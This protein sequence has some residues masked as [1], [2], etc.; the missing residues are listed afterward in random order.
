[1]APKEWCPSVK[2]RPC[3]HGIVP[4]FECEDC[5]RPNQHSMVA[6]SDCW[7]LTTTHID[8]TP[9]TFYNDREL[10]AACK[11]AGVRHRPDSAFVEQRYEGYDMRAGRQRVEEGSGRGLPGSWV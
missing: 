6:G 8:G 11:A 3:P 5:T 10:Q 4:W 7:P 9:R 2:A 1:M